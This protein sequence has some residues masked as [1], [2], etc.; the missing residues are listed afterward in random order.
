[1]RHRSDLHAS[2]LERVL[3]R[4]IQAFGGWDA[5]GTAD[6]IELRP[7]HVLLDADDANRVR[8][9]VFV[10]PLDTSL[11]RRA[12]AATAG[13]SWTAS[14]VQR[15]ES[16]CRESGTPLA[17]VTDD[18]RWVL[19]WAPR[20]APSAEELLP[21]DDGSHPPFQPTQRREDH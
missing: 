4:V 8:L 12:D 17:L 19:V 16:W 13:D 14:P 18:D 6:G 2:A 11:D 21:H 15:A 20:G 7:D 5:T 3:Y 9:G 1:M 10:W